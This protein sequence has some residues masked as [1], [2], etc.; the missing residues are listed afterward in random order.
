[1]KIS[2]R[3]E[4]KLINLDMQ[5]IDFFRDEP[6]EIYSKV[7]AFNQ[8]GGRFF[9]FNGKN[10]KLLDAKLII[11]EQEFITDRFKDNNETGK[12]TPTA[13]K[14]FNRDSIDS[15]DKIGNLDIYG[16]CDGYYGYNDYIENNRNEAL[17]LIKN[18]SSLLV[19]SRVPCMVILA[20]KFGLVIKT[21]KRGVYLNLLRLKPEGKRPMKH[22]D[23]INGYRIKPGVILK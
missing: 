18:I 14:N 12:K 23:F 16:G 21:A 1:M 20:S 9:M 11:D 22:I 7:R 10:I 8:S 5:R 6:L 17:E 15:T 13:V 2:N 4:S 3:T 19:A